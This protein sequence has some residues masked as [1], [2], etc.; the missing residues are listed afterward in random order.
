MARRSRSGWRALCRLGMEEMMEKM[1][2]QS[3]LLRE[4]ACEACGRTFS[5]ESDKQRGTSVV[6]REG[7]Q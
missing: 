2:R 7:S 1:N 6:R 5:G 3:A 4:V